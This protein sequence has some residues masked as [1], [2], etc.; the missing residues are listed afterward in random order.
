MSYDISRRGFIKLGGASALGLGSMALLTACG[1]S[2]S[3]SASAVGT[4]GAGSIKVGLLGPYTGD[5]APYG[6]AVRNGVE[7]YA[8]QINARGGING[9]QV[10]LDSMDERGNSIEAVNAYGKMVKDGAVA[11]LGDVTSAPSIAVAQASAADNMPL[12]SASTTVAAF[13]SYGSNAFRVCAT[14]TFQGRLLADLAADEGYQTVAVIYNAISDYE[15]G[16]A[17]VFIG[18]AKARGL[19]LCSEQGYTVGDVDFAALL[20]DVLDTDPDAILVPS[21]C[22]VDAKIVTQARQLGYK[23]VF[24]GADGWAGITDYAS[25]QD[26]EGCF[27]DCSFVPSDDEKVQQF[28]SDYRAEYGKDPGNFDALGYDASMV[29]FG[30][31]QSVEKGGTAEYGTADYKQAIIEALASSTTEGVTGAIKYTGTGDPVRPTTVFKFEGGEQKVHKT[32]EA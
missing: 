5:M 20:T 22:Q 31:I 9:R 10:E 2:G 19:A 11:V 14:D 26:L 8:K 27:Y 29:V 16:I 17:S 21:Y 7:L 15:A 13:V 18:E 4:A 32:V 12:V 25:A 28:I 23:G 30:A 24:L 6:L 1:G 3:D